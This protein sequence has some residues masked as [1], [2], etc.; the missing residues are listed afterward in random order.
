MLLRALLLALVALAPVAAA[1]TGPYVGVLREGQQAAHAY[2]NH[3]APDEP[4]CP[5]NVGPVWWVV[6]LHY[7]PPTS[8][9]ALDVEGRGAAVGANGQA[10]VTFE[11]APCEALDIAVTALDAAVSTAYAVQVGSGTTPPA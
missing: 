7:A 10:T 4:P 9:L 3:P 6:T 1:T 8:V 2:D 5:D 11:G